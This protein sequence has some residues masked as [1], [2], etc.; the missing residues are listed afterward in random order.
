MHRILSIQHIGVMAGKIPWLWAVLLASIISSTLVIVRDVHL[1]RMGNIQLNTL[2]QQEHEHLEQHGRLLLER[3]ALLSPYRLETI[4]VDRLNMHN[5]KF[6]D[7]GVL[8]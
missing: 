5:P 4:A 8:L 2:Y 7:I 3:S 6:G 1:I